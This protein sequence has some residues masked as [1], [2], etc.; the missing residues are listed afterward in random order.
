MFGKVIMSGVEGKETQTYALQTGLK[1][2]SST[3]SIKV[4][5]PL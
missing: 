1:S 4:N 2:Q 3:C 5:E